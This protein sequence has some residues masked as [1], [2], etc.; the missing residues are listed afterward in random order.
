[1]GVGIEHEIRHARGA[2]GVEGLL[3]ALGIERAL[4][5]L[6][7]DHRDRLALII[8][9]GQK[10]GGLA[11]AMEF[12]LGRVHFLDGNDKLRF[13]ESPSFRCLGYG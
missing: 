6:G 2:S 9:G 4:D 11:S 7:G 12:G 13:A 1:M 10:T 5:G 8:A 3:D